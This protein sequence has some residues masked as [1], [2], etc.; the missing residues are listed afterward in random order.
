MATNDHA[1][2]RWRQTAVRLSTV[3]PVSY[4]VPDEG[5]PA[6]CC[7]CSPRRLPAAQHMIV[8][9]H[10]HGRLITSSYQRTTVV[11]TATRV[12]VRAGLSAVPPRRRQRQPAGQI[13][14]R[15]TGCPCGMDGQARSAPAAGLMRPD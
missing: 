11:S 14:R 10:G 5:R 2:R 13:L 6:T 7:A 15:A 3:R 8:H 1:R 12:G 4:T 9:A